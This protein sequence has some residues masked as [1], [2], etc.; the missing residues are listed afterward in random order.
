MMIRC[1]GK[2]HLVD[3]GELGQMNTAKSSHLPA[4]RHDHGYFRLVVGSGGHVLDLSHDKEAIYDATEHHVLAVQEVTL[5]ARDEKL[6][7]VTVPTTVRL[8]GGGGGGQ[9]SPS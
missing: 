7:S 2:R 5:G 8:W 3:D 1:I 9:I 4:L 6:A